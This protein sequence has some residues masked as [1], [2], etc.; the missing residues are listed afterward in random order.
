MS[1]HYI[2][3]YAQIYQGEQVDRIICLGYVV[4]DQVAA[5]VLMME[6]VLEAVATSGMVLAQVKKWVSVIVIWVTEQ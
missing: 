3:F 2:C 4:M 5:D 6:V 1:T